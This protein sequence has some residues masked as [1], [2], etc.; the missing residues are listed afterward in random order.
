[1]VNYWTASPG[2][3]ASDP[4]QTLENVWNIFRSPAYGGKEALNVN[5]ALHWARY[6]G[7][8]GKSLGIVP[9]S[10]SV[11]TSRMHLPTDVKER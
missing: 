2:N 8:F 5:Y 4:I 1:M 7:L 6:Q 11:S 3:W 9:V 10:V